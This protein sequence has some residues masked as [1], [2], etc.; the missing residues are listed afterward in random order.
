MPKSSLGKSLRAD[1]KAYRDNVLDRLCKEML[2][3]AQTSK[4]GKVPYGF[5][6]KLVVESAKEEPW[7]NRNVINHAYMKFSLKDEEQSSLIATKK[8]VV[9]PKEKNAVMG[10]PKGST[11]VKK[12]HLREVLL[13]AKNEIATLYLHEKKKSKREGKKLPNGWL[14]NKIAEIS[15]M[16][17]IPSNMPISKFTIRNRKEGQI[18]LQGGGP[19]SLMAPVEPH[20]V[21]LI[22]AMAGMRR[23][24][25]TSEAIALGNDLII[26]TETE[27]R[28][29]EW[30]KNRNEFNDNSPVLGRKWWQ[31]FKKG[32]SHRLVTKQG[33]KFALDRSSALTY[34][35]V[36]K[37]MT[38]YTRV[39]WSVELLSNWIDPHMNFKVI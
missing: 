7:I 25:T 24:L 39:W 27:K 8:P 18:V 15:A 33:Q 3:A 20:L 21:E 31:L 2:Y 32:W 4:N 19:E 35:N 36:K 37:C 22:C 6:N 10:R 17:G 16:R 5:V 28:I 14:N 34:G 30:K 29:I 23:C 1:K 12:R 9:A 26:G 38:T 11:N 13:A